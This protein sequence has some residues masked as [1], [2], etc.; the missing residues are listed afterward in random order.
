M[1]DKRE[2]RVGERFGKT[3]RVEAEARAARWAALLA[4]EPADLVAEF[5]RTA[6]DR[7]DLGDVGMT[8]AHYE[9]NVA[10]F[11][12]MVREGRPKQQLVGYIT[13]SEMVAR[14]I[15]K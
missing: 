4:M 5:E 1:A 15:R 9:A 2:I 6:A 10:A 3:M 13:G 8:P 12:H 14:N 11:K 7:R